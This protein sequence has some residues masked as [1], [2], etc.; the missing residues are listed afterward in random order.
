MTVDE[1]AEAHSHCVLDP[2][3]ASRKVFEAVSGDQTVIKQGL[4]EIDAPMPA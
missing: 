3:C 2:G 1:T 4:A